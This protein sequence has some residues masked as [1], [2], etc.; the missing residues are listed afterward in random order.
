MPPFFGPDSLGSDVVK[1]FPD[2]VRKKTCMLSCNLPP[3]LTT[4]VLLT[5]MGKR[6][7]ATATA[8][9]LAQ[10]DAAALILLGPSQPETQPS[11]DEINKKYPKVKVLFV[12]VD[13]G[14]LAS[15]REAANTINDLDVP[16]D[17]IIG[18]PTVI[19][20]RYERTM[21]G[22]ESHLQVNYLSHF[23]L[24]NRLLGRMPE[25]SRVIMVS[26]SIRPDSPAPSFGDPGFSVCRRVGCLGRTDEAGWRNIPSPRRLRAIY[27]RQ[28]PV[29]EEPG[30]VVSRAIHNCFFCQSWE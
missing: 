18:Y 15:V 30:S 24:V 6:E 8:E 14:S 26:S 13:L 16:I 17:G 12:T 25:G 4:T 7:I 11:I 27:V 21:D 9:A 1:A 19:A 29:H 22:V 23:L 28:C 2:S 10:G 3:K 5:G 20:A